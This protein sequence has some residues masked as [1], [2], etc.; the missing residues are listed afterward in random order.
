MHLVVTGGGTGGHI[1]PAVAVAE[2][3]RKNLPDTT[4][5]YIGSVSGPEAA[6]AGEAGIPFDGVEVAGV[7]GK[8]PITALKSMIMSLRAAFR[9]RKLLKR[10][11]ADCVVGT[12]GYAMVPACIAAITMR[13][14]LVLHEMNFDPGHATRL[15]A[16]RAAAIAVAYAGTAEFLPASSRRRVVVTGVPVRPEIEAIASPEAREEAK[17]EATRVFGL[18][19]EK[20]TLLLFGGSQGAEALNESAWAELAALA[21]RVDVQ[22]VHVTGRKNIEDASLAGFQKEVTGRGLIYRPFPYMDRMDLAYALADL[23]VCRAGAGTIA[24]IMATGVP[25]VLV[26][27]PHAAGHQE[28]NARALAETGAVVVVPQVGGSATEAVRRALE[29]LDDDASLALMRKA[30]E[31]SKR[32]GGAKGIASLVEEMT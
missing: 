32:P 13:V 11:G 24:E 17:N 19:A 14:P 23:A 21:D 5:S 25:A 22:V 29:L 10:L 18:D 12:G 26:P 28:R 1:Y 4:V 16:R 27:Y 9:C 30:A 7:V 15:L 2:Y 8:S 3:A 20:K 6:I 31:E